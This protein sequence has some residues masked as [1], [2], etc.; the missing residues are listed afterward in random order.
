METTAFDLLDEPWIRVMT[1]DRQIR[2]L[3][4]TQALLQ[5]HEYRRLAGELPTQDVA[6]LRLLLAVLHTVFYRVDLDGADDPI[7]ERGQALARWRALRQ[8]GRLPEGPIRAYLEHWHDR[9]W[10]FHPE[11]PFYQVPGADV[12]TLYKAQKLNG[13]LSESSNK[14]RLFPVRAGVAKERLTYAEAARWLV[15]MMGFDDVSTKVETGTGIGWLGQHIDLYAVGDNLFETLLLN[16][17]FLK[18]G[19]TLWE[20]KN[21]PAWEKDPAKTAKKKVI[22]VPGDQA[23]LLTLQSRRTILVRDGDMVIGCHTTGGDYFGEDGA[24]AASNE[25]MTQWIIDPKAKK[26][27]PRFIPK[28]PCADRAMWRDYE[29][30]VDKRQRQV[31]IPGVTAW[32]QRLREK[33]LLPNRTIRLSAVGIVY[34][35]KNCST[36]DIVSDHLDFHA[37]LLNEAGTLWNDLVGRKIGEIDKAAER[38]EKLAE[39]LYLAASGD[40]QP[41]SS[42]KKARKEQA[43]QEFYAAVDIPFRQWL[44]SIDPEQGDGEELR[45]EKD[46]QWRKT[47]CRIALRQ[48]RDMVDRAGTPAFVG[49]WVKKEGKKAKKDE[50]EFYASPIAL[51]RF[52]FGIGKLFAIEN[53][54]K[55][56]QTK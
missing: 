11:R 29:T 50:K 6:I 7:E 45:A 9:F 8:A 35:S 25:Q 33:G 49:R 52:V 14:P 54:K 36:A 23:G 16:L 24:A 31:P 43:K 42:V 18:D 15:T 2:E 55:E 53:R 41:K 37:A 3:S 47:A 51:D 34:G 26:D 5:S 44:S 12:G 38:I 13:E 17:V 28:S 4:L 56:G 30:I 1:H 40:D 21:V 10:L 32:L 46:E 20:E 19:N 27:V 48:G 39:E 22:A